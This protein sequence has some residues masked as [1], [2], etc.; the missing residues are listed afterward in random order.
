MATAF[1]SGDYLTQEQL[2]IVL[3][4]IRTLSS[5]RPQDDFFYSVNYEWL[6]NTRLPAGYPG[7]TTL[8]KLT[9]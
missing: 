3:N 2:D 8:T 6:T 5:V 1:G 9:R 7:M 4:K